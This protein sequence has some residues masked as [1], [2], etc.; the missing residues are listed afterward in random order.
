M[1]GF[2]V[3]IGDSLCSFELDGLQFEMKEVCVRPIENYNNINCHIPQTEHVSKTSCI[4]PLFTF[5]DIILLWFIVSTILVRKYG[6][7]SSI[8]KDN[9]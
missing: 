7:L 1:S 9:K 6:K 5:F 4:L 8:S 2:C 3:I